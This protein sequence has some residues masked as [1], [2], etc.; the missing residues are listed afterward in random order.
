MD[1]A[2]SKLL[3]LLLATPAVSGLVWWSWR[4]RMAA[5]AQWA[6][7]G[8]WDR[9]LPGHRP[10]RM[11][12]TAL[13]LG[14]A[15]A[16]TALALARPRWGTGAQKVERQGVDIVFVLDTSLS[17]ATRDVQPS[18]M[19]IAQ[20]L[21]RELIRRLPSHRTALVQAEGDGVVMVPLTVDNAVIG[22]LLDAVQPGT[23]PTPGT[24]LAK[25]LE[26]ALGL[27]PDDGDKHRVLILISDG[28]DHGSAMRQAATQLE[29]AG[30]V[31]HALGVG[32]PEGKPL[33]L[34]NLESGQALTYKKDEDG[35]VVVSRLQEAT[36]ESL[37]RTTG[38]VYLRATSAAL[39]LD[40][41]VSRIQAM[42]SRSF[43]SETISTL[44][45]Q[46]QWPAALAILALAAYLALPVFAR[47][48]E[49][50]P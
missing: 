24:E 10:G 27:F 8:L 50:R 45:E 32:T 18:R 49:S 30:V 14:L 5:T 26:L 37:S 17:M 28:E 3:W 33:E 2:E 35:N 6:S 22:L 36:L 9:L 11:T 31:V 25:A 47:S 23:L 40:A 20:T 41:I 34:P 12:T 1:F 4:R 42:E 21:L 15:V 29:E 48:S 38:G 19:W 43:G 39:D 44:E 46:F 13:L 16:G 7:R